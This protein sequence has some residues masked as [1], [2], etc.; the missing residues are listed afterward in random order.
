MHFCLSGGGS[1]LLFRGGRPYRQ[2]R[3]SLK[4]Q[5]KHPRISRTGGIS[6]SKPAGP[7][8]KAA[9]R[10]ARS[11]LYKTVT[12]LDKRKLPHCSKK[13]QHGIIRKEY[14]CEGNLAPPPA[15][16]LGR[17]RT[18]LPAGRQTNGYRPYAYQGLLLIKE[19]NKKKTFLRGLAAHSPQTS[20]AGTLEPLRDAK[21]VWNMFGF[22]RSKL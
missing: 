6:K 4:D 21:T 5:N 16:T 10:L 17:V 8:R 13:Q 12:I 9:G 1:L 3:E 11:L 14:L 7:I 18:G 22:F 19:V 20:P 15:N 2:N